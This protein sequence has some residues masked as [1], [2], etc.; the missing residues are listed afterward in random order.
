MTWSRVRSCP[1]GVALCTKVSR[2]ARTEFRVAKSGNFSVLAI[3]RNADGAD[4]VMKG[5]R[6][7]SNDNSSVR[8]PRALFAARDMVPNTKP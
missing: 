7:L 5:K 8:A 3:V 1:Y 6:D 4:C 2:A